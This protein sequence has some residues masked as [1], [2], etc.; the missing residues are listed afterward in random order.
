MTIRL[1]DVQYEDGSLSCL[2]YLAYDDAQTGKRPGVLVVHEAWGLGEHAMERARMLAALGYVAFAADLY[3]ARRQFD[4]SNARSAIGGF[5]ANPATLR[6]RARAALASLASQPQVDPALLF[7][8]GFCFGGS[9]VLELARDGTDLL[10]V[11]A[12]YAK[13]ATQTPAATGSIKAGI[14]VLTGA[15]DPLVP[16][17]ERSAFEKEMRDAKADWQLILYGKAQHSFTNPKADGAM[18]GALYNAD[19][20]RRSWLAMQNFFDEK[21]KG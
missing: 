16:A 15:D 11:V 14:L 8:I 1:R 4:I 18:P 10:G 13:L 9:T 3:G 6:Q 21:L 20:D 2:G 19:A 7:A 5:M 12:F 17:D